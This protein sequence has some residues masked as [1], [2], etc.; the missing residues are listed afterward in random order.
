MVAPPPD[1]ARPWRWK[2]RWRREGL[3][4]TRFFGDGS[5]AKFGGGE[6]IRS[7][8]RPSHMHRQGR[9]LMPHKKI[10]CT[11][12]R[13]RRRHVVVVAQGR[14]LSTVEMATR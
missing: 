4:A 12:W 14:A 5:E 8:R 11:L 1:G 9:S 10:L 2:R 3:C 6:W 13:W 7:R